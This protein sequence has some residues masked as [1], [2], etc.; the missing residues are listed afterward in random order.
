VDGRHVASWRSAAGRRL[1][2]R[3]RRR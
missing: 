1:S 2:R 3:S